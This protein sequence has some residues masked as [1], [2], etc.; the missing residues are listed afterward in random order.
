MKFE[1][2]REGFNSAEGERVDFSQNGTRFTRYSTLDRNCYETS[3]QF[4]EE[5]QRDGKSFHAERTRFLLHPLLR[6]Q[7]KRYQPSLRSP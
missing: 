4:H 6:D 3:D 7:L 5:S 1:I 2:C